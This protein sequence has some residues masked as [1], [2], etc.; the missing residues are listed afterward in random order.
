MAIEPK[1]VMSCDPGVVSGAVVFR[2]TRVSVDALFDNLADG[3][4]LGD[5]F[6]CFPTVQPWQVE[7][8]LM[9]AKREIIGA[10]KVS[11]DGKALASA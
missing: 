6:E 1:D 4:S 10:M 3:M 5:F 2:G 8:A 9:L 7:E 11:S